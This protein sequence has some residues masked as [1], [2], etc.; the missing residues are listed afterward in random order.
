[1]VEDIEMQKEAAHLSLQIHC[2]KVLWVTQ[3]PL[4]VIHSQDV[5]CQRAKLYWYTCWG[6]NC[7]QGVVGKADDLPLEELKRGGMA[8]SQTYTLACD[9]P[10]NLKSVQGNAYTKPGKQNIGLVELVKM[11]HVKGLDNPYLPIQERSGLE[12]GL[13]K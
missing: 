9:K 1:M 4:K 6:W 2:V 13:T 8:L 11:T 7:C 10:M 12:L 3:A 5:V